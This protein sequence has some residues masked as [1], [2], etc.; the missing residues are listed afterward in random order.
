MVAEKLARPARCRC[1][2]ASQR[3]RARTL[4]AEKLAR[5]ARCRCVVAPQ[6]L[7]PTSWSSRSWHAR[8]SVG[9]LSHLSTPGPK[10]CS[11]RSWH[12]GHGVGV[13][14]H[15]SA[16]GHSPPVAEKLARLARCRC[17]VAPQRTQTLTPVAEK[18]ARPARCRC[19]VAPQRTP[20]PNTHAPARVVG[21]PRGRAVTTVP[22]RLLLFSLPCPRSTVRSRSAA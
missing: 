20:F 11:L 3:T 4:A 14:S 17:V 2:V 10:R 21:H 8:R 22:T 7:G 12:A 15:L 1:V 18:L 5:L 6:R 13:L 16:P 9:V 19:V